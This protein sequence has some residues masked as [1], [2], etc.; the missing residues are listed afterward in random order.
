MKLN[1][2]IGRS[3]R[4]KTEYILNQIKDIVSNDKL[5]RIIVVVPEQATFRMERELIE[6][7]GLPGLFGISVVSFDRLVHEILSACGGRTLNPL[8]FIGKTMVVRALLDEHRDSLSVFGKSAKMSG[9]E[10]KMAEMLT[11]LKRQDTPVTELTRATELKLLPV[12]RQ[13]L[14]DISLLYNAYTEKLADQSMDNEDMISLAIEKAES[15]N[16]FRGAHVFVD[17]FDLL[18]NQLLRLLMIAVHQAAASTITFKKSPVASPDYSVFE[19]EEKLYTRVLEAAKDLGMKPEEIVLSGTDTSGTKFVSPEILHLEQNLFAYPFVPFAESPQDICLTALDSQTLEVKDVCAKLIDLV[20]LGY[21]FRDI[22]VCV[23]DMDTYREELSFHLDENHIPFFMDAKTKL[24]DTAFAEFLISL[25]DFVLYKDTADF[26]VHIKSGF[27]GAASDELFA[28]ENYIRRYQIKGYMLN[29]AFK[30]TD[31]ETEKAK[32]SL[33]DPIFELIRSLKSAKSAESYGE[34][35]ITYLKICQVDENIS[36]FAQK[37]EASGDLTGAQ[38]FSQVFEKIIAVVRQACVMFQGQTTS[39]ESFVSAVKAGLE[40]VEIAVI[41]PSTD[42]VLVGDFSRTV[43]PPMKVLF[44]L[45]LNDGKIPT[46]PDTSA[47]LTDAEKK[48]LENQGVRAGYR[49]RFFEERLRIYSVFAGPTQKLFLSYPSS[50]GKDPAKPSV[51]IARIQKL[52]PKM[53]SNTYIPREKVYPSLAKNSIFR[54]LSLSLNQKLE[55]LP[56]DHTWRDVYAY[57]ENDPD[58]HPRIRRITERLKKTDKTESINPALVRQLYSPLTASISRAE[59][60]FACPMQYFLDYGIHP[61]KEEIFEETPL[62]MGN[63]LHACLYGFVSAVKEKKQTWGALADAELTK[64]A[65]AVCEQNKKTHHQGIFMDKR[66]TSIYER[67]KLDFLSA[68][69]TIRD[70]LSDTDVSVYAAELTLKNA[71]YLAFTLDDGIEL[72]L[73]CKVDRVDVLD[74]GSSKVVRIVDYKLS[75]KTAALKDV[76]YGLN[77]QLLIYLKF[78]LEYFKALGETVII[79]GAFYYDLSLPM[80]EDISPEKLLKDKRMNGFLV[81]NA[82]INEKMSKSDGKNLIATQGSIKNDGSLSK[83]TKTIFTTEQF[84]LLF[85]HCESLMQQAF[86]DILKG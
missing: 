20:N 31:S 57:F 1:F 27:L 85:S 32:K 3:G 61:K 12:T 22:A 37:R 33:T 28:V 46:S 47:I 82:A 56:V 9:F 53:T 42:D 45:G 55:G 81:D 74:D 13:K 51:L 21:R 66:F 60:F 11:E 18:T 67:L 6:T 17:G 77:I 83:T 23:S 4:G 29:Y 65:V 71:E 59:R 63:F 62:E 26:I 76:Y 78:V 41:P 80:S 48:A 34:D 30:H 8:D 5:C 50:Q 86:R 69:R 44:L 73:A 68:V 72:K 79:G 54:D 38:V 58:W 40:A 84:D 70:Q 36:R 16:F 49:D 7:C 64:T 52:F 19:P 2:V 39:F 25:L 43:F 14:A 75:G 35:I 15:Q 24:M 10:I